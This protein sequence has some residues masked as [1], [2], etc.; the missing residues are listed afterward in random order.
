M[1][2]LVTGLSGLLSGAMSGRNFSGDGPSTAVMDDIPNQTLRVLQTIQTE[3][4]KTNQRLDTL[5][6]RVESGFADTSQ[7]VD[8]L[9]ERVDTLTERIDVLSERVETGFGDVSRRLDA[10]LAISGSHHTELETPR[11]VDWLARQVRSQV[12]RP[13]SGSSR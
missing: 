7:R 6:V 5:I 10:V 11:P 2:S 8:T 1:P 13:G 9:I 3:I 12:A 4:V